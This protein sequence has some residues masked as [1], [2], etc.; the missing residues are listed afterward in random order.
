MLGIGVS[1]AAGLLA[2]SISG[3]SPCTKDCAQAK[4]ACI[5]GKAAFKTAG[6]ACL[7]EF[8]AK[9]QECK[10]SPAATDVCSPSGAFLLD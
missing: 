4:K 10:A 3:A 8:K 1:V 7:A 2:A 6:K 9:K 5:A